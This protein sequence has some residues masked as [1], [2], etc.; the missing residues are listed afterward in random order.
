MNP[1]DAFDHIDLSPGSLLGDVARVIHALLYEYIPQRP[2]E[3]DE[4][5]HRRLLEATAYAMVQ[6]LAR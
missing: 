6:G 4:E 5:Y 3:T 1:E 2:D